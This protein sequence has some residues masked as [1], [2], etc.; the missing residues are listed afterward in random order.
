MH[1]VPIT[2]IHHC[3]LLDYEHQIVSVVLSHCRYS[4]KVGEAHNV[5]YDYRALERHIL[6]KFIHGKPKI[7]YD[8]SDIPQVEYSKEI[9][10]RK[11]FGA[12]RKNVHPQVS[13]RKRSHVIL[14]EELNV[15]TVLYLDLPNCNHGGWFILNSS[16]IDDCSSLIIAHCA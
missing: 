15:Y 13:T 1:E 7:L 16:K 4:L 5:Q 2:H 8:S 10:T 11:T 6:N 14:A 12:V 9:Y 3:H